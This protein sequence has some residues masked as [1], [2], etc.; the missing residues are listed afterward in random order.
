[1]TERFGYDPELQMVI[2][3]AN[4]LNKGRLLFWRWL[5]THGLLEHEVAGPSQ[6]DIALA[7]TAQD[8]RLACIPKSKT[9]QLREHMIKTGDY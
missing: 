6:G 4:P 2:E 9:E 8:G 3:P 7:I 5:G 1:M